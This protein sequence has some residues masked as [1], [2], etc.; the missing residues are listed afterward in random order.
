MYAQQLVL[1]KSV[2]HHLLPLPLLP[3]RILVQLLLCQPLPRQLV[4][5][6]HI[7]HG[8]ETM[9]AGSCEGHLI[10]PGRSETSGDCGNR[11]D[12]SST[13]SVPAEAAGAER[14]QMGRQA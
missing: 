1:S 4:L 12:S 3:L 14:L 8:C 10:F 9:S 5:S 11:S 2:G 6:Q 13:R 7:L